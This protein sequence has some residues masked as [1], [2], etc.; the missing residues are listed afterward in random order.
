MIAY[1]TDPADC[2]KRTTNGNVD[3]VTIAGA[4]I[5]GSDVVTGVVMDAAPECDPVSQKILGTLKI[6]RSVLSGLNSV[7]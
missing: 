2:S 3:R 7:C 5:D 4:G 1:Y 6:N